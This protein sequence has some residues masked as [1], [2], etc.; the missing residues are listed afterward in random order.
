ME[1]LSWKRRHFE[2]PFWE[3]SNFSGSIFFVVLFSAEFFFKCHRQ[4][5]VKEK[6][7]S[8][9]RS[10]QYIARREGV[11][12]CERGR[13][14]KQT[15]KKTEKKA[16]WWT[17]FCV[18]VLGAPS[19]N[20]FCDI[21]VFVYTLSTFFSSFW[22]LNI[23]LW[24]FGWVDPHRVFSMGPWDLLCCQ[25]FGDL[26]LAI[27]L[28]IPTK[29]HLGFVGLG[30][31]CQ[32]VHYE[33]LQLQKS[34]RDSMRFSSPQCLGRLFSQLYA[35]TISDYLNCSCSWITHPSTLWWLCG[36]GWKLP[37]YICIRLYTVYKKPF[38]LAPIN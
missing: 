29:K 14:E 9:E 27:R 21:C 24:D 26:C 31:R 28:R 32:V 4:A 5:F 15:E 11:S 23:S 37:T 7:N 19:K 17:L 18:F 25:F 1:L 34:G 36:S 2:I 35:S 30:Y 20:H 8:K 16:G 6:Y 22:L 12:K 33:T 38:L 10:F 13:E 3:S